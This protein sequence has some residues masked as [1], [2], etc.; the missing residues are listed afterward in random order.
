[1]LGMER[2]VGLLEAAAIDATIAEVEKA[3]E[4][5]AENV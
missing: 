5:K 1:V 3:I 2:A 4:E